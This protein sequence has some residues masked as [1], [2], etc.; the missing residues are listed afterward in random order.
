MN[1]TTKLAAAIIFCALALAAC[2]GGGDGDSTSAWAVDRG[3][4]DGG[5]EASYVVTPS[6]NGSGGTINQSGPVPATPGTTVS[7]TLTP[8]PGYIAS[9]GGTCGGTLGSNN[10]YTT[11]TITK[12]CTVVAA[13]VVL[14]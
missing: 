6:V 1:T 5:V 14:T 7:F 11:K 10:V 4:G 9:V 3:T 2:G 8:S 13:F 12:D